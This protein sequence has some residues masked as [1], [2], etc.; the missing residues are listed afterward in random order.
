MPPLIPPQNAQL[1]MKSNMTTLENYDNILIKG[2]R[3]GLQPQ[4]GRNQIIDALYQIPTTNSDEVNSMCSLPK[5]AVDMFQTDS[6]AN[7]PVMMRTSTG[8]QIQ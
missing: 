1:Q 4:I 8:F 7:R 2:V 6:A 5:R 3:K